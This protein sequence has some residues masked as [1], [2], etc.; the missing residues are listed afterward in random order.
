MT[1]QKKNKTK[2]YLEIAVV[3]IL[4]VASVFMVIFLIKNKQ[5][6]NINLGVLNE[7]QMDLNRKGKNNDKIDVFKVLDSLEKFG[8]WPVEDTNP[9][10]VPRSNPFAL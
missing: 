5:V 3:I 6:D 8:E 7:K 10:P 1:V 4:V 2:I 9:R